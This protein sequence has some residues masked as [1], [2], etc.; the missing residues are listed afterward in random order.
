MGEVLDKA[1]KRLKTSDNVSRYRMGIL[2][3]ITAL[4]RDD[5]WLNTSAAKYMR[6]LQTSRQECREKLVSMLEEIRDDLK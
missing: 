1:Y 3:Q 5:K 6:I 2:K 4:L